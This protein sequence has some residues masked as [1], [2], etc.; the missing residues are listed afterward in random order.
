MQILFQAYTEL[1]PFSVEMTSSSNFKGLLDLSAAPV[2]FHL[3][4]DAGLLEYISNC[5][6]DLETLNSKQVNFKPPASEADTHNFSLFPGCF[7]I[8]AG[9]QFLLFNFNQSNFNITMHVWFV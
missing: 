1:Q 4:S 2:L 6:D 3:Q 8:W 7:Y 5:N 9:M